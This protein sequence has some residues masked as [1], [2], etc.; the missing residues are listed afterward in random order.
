MR[1][2]KIPG[3]S[4]YT[5]TYNM[6]SNNSEPTT[7]SIIRFEDSHQV[8][9]VQRYGID[10]YCAVF[11]EDCCMNDELCGSSV[12]GTYLQIIDEIKDCIYQ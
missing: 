10:D 11:T 8:I 1:T 3:S 2:V 9:I 6:C 12:R 4:A 7:E 5:E